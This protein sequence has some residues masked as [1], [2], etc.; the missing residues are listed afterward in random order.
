M[1][2]NEFV[3]EVYRRMSLR[4]PAVR[5]KPTLSEIQAQPTV[6]QAVREYGSLLPPDKNASI[7]DIGFGG[8]WF[9]ATCLKLGY[10]N[11]SGADFGIDHKSHVREWAPQ[12]VSLFEIERDI[13]DF[14]ADRPAEQYEFVHMSHVIEH[15]PKYSLLWVV[16]AIYRSLKPGGVLLLRTPNM[17]GPTP[18][19]SF[20]VTLAHEYGFSGSNLT[21]LLG[22]CGFDDVAIHQLP[23]FDR[24]FKQVIGRFMRWSYIQHSRLKHRLFGVNVG[25]Q[26]GPELVISGRRGNAPPLFDRRYR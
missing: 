22:I 12:A 19:S 4:Y 10:T 23:V 3:A 9:I 2:P 7:L 14:L 8:G 11:I 17:E 16:D 20:Y 15:I 26:F 6:L 5:L 13:G 24:T 18:N 1:E 25:R 21:S